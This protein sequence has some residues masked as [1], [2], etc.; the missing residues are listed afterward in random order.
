MYTHAYAHE[1]T[2]ACMTPSTRWTLIPRP[3]IYA[4]KCIH[5][6]IHTYIN[7]YMYKYIHTCIYIHISCPHTY[8]HTHIYTHAYKMHMWTFAKHVWNDG[9]AATAREARLDAKK[10]C[11]SPYPLQSGGG[12]PSWPAAQSPVHEERRICAEHPQPTA[13]HRTTTTAHR[14]DHIRLSVLMRSRSTQF[15]VHA[16]SQL[17]RGPPK[18]GHFSAILAGFFSAC[19]CVCVCVCVYICVCVC[20]YIHVSLCIACMCSLFHL[21]LGNEDRG[22]Q[23]VYESACCLAWGV[24]FERWKDRGVVCCLLYF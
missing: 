3:T 5:I 10:L 8:T 23:P 7:A 9:A 15:I 6:H 20:T 11:P 24:I 22:V 16:S 14:P 13:A 1:N 17:G 4:Q 21:A 18:R 19:V 12:Y 2:I